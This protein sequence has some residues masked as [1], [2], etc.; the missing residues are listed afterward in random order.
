M[1]HSN[2]VFNHYQNLITY[3]NDDIS[4]G[5]IWFLVE[6]SKFYNNKGDSSGSV[7]ENSLILIQ[8]NYEGLYQSEIYIKY[9]SFKSNQNVTFL[10]V[11]EAEIHGTNVI[12][13]T[14]AYQ[15]CPTDTLGAHNIPFRVYIK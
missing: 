10:T 9:N 2:D 14:T 1:F 3:N 13:D 8:N 7:K 5:F 11:E 6:N 12:Q 4:Y 15:E